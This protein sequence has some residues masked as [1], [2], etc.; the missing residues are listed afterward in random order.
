MKTNQNDYASAMASFRDDWEACTA[1]RHCPTIHHRRIRT[2]SLLELSFPE[3]RGRTKVIPR[4]FTEKSCV[5]LV[6][7][8]LREASS[9]W[10]GVRVSAFDLPKIA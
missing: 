4:F 7:S 6:F 1:F 2:T 5:K 3:R 10:L 9:R 8:T